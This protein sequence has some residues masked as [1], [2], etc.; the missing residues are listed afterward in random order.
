M[1]LMKINH[2]MSLEEL[3]ELNPPEDN[4]SFHEEQGK[5]ETPNE[6]H[7]MEADLAIGGELRE[8][9]DKYTPK[10]KSPKDVHPGRSGK[11]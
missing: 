11:E 6:Q 2:V 5:L 7:H 9:Q 1:T 3:V 4:V 8:N 10:I